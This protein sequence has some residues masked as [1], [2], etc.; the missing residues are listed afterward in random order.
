MGHFL[1]DFPLRHDLPEVRALVDQLTNAYWSEARIVPVLLKAGVPPGEIE[2]GPTARITWMNALSEARARDRLVSLLDVI[3]AD[4][5]ATAIHDAVR[6]L[7]APTPELEPSVPRGDDGLPL[8]A[9]AWPSAPTPERFTGARSTLVDLAFLQRGLAAARAVARMRVSFPG[10]EVSGT[11]FLIAPDLVLTNHHVLFEREE[12]GESARRAR[13]EVWLGY[14]DDVDGHPLPPVVI[15]CDPAA[16]V[17][18]AKH[19]WAVVRLPSPVD[20]QRFPWLPL[21]EA[22][23][24]EVGDSVCIVQHPVG[25]PKKV[26][27]L[28]N[29]VVDVSDDLV[30]YQTDTDA[31][32]SGSPVFD[33]SWRVVAIHHASW[34]NGMGPR[35]E[36]R[37][38]G[39]RIDRVRAALVQGGYLP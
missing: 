30:Q 29:L 16:I 3:L 10:R 15:P 18:A 12:R 13:V 35:P 36:V 31:G 5:S 22:V 24:V 26:G 8:S 19:D 33:V 6:R 9:G 14:E 2:F 7:R 21:P 27:I 25:A 34:S 39:V 37:N 4:G 28:R 1:Q 32:S 11:G 23:A 17:G 38:Q 20:A